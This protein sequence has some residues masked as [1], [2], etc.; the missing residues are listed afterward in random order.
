MVM[1]GGTLWYFT[2]APYPLFADGKAWLWLSLSGLVGYL[3][4]I[5]AGVGQ[6]IGL[7]LSKVRMNY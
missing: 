5:D 4:G 2:G 7:V 1:L 6:G 3:F